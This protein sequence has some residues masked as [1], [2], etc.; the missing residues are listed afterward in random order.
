MDIVAR[1]TISY[2]LQQPLLEVGRQRAGLH[3]LQG[4]LQEVVGAIVGRSR[5][6]ATKLCATVL[7]DKCNE[8]RQRVYRPAV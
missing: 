4:L 3:G 2:Q 8:S 7:L 6:G 1:C 5:S